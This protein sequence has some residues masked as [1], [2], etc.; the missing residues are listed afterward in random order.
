VGS[1]EEHGGDGNEAWTHSGEAK[2]VSR[3]GSGRSGTPQRAM[4]LALPRVVRTPS[5]VDAALDMAAHALAARDAL[6]GG[7]GRGGGV[8]W[9]A[10]SLRLPAAARPADRLR[11]PLAVQGAADAAEGAAAVA[12]LSSL[13]RASDRRELTDL[14]PSLAL[15]LEAGSG[16][17][18]G[19]RDEGGRAATPSSRHGVNERRTQVEAARRPA[20][21]GGGWTTDRWLKLRQRR[22]GAA[23][24]GWGDGA[25]GAAGDVTAYVLDAPRDS[26]DVLPIAF[27]QRSAMRDYLPGSVPPDD[28]IDGVWGA[29]TAAGPGHVFGVPRHA[30]LVLWDRVA[31]A[32]GFHA[33]DVD[34]YVSV[35]RKWLSDG[36]RTRCLAVLDRNAQLLFQRLR[37]LRAFAQ[38]LQTAAVAGTS[39]RVPI[40]PFKC[41]RVACC[42]RR[43]CPLF[44]V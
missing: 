9:L 24:A 35:V 8:H 11:A 26:S 4:A 1:S 39:A 25:P 38:V 23:H 2:G 19:G 12:A 3:A 14:D 17:R 20:L 31:S 40:P 29:G 15:A 34:T 42:T 32:T 16:E 5:A 6:G 7:G 33:D 36:V 22:G 41:A 43:L 30:R 27:E 10:R 28:T 13:L 18:G 37:D 21:D 44:V